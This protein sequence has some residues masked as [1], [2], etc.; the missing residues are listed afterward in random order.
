[1][2]KD[3]NKKDVTILA[4]PQQKKATVVDYNTADVMSMIQKITGSVND[5]DIPEEH[6]NELLGMIREQKLSYS[7]KLGTEEAKT[8]ELVIGD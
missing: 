1:M 4:F 5:P 8:E 3:E 2:T 7:F 6:V